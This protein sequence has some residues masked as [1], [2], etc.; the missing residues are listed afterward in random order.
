LFPCR[1]TSNH[2]MQMDLQE[3]SRNKWRSRMIQSHVSH[4][5]MWIENKSWLWKNIR[6]GCK[7]EHHQ[8]S[9][10]FIRIK[11][12]EG[13]SFGC[14]NGIFKWTSSWWSLHA[15]VARIWVPRSEHLVCKLFW[16][17]HGLKQMPFND[18]KKLIVFWRIVFAKV[19]I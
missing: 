15:I 2:Y 13:A 17:L 8:S 3:I 18:F 9:E 4:K 10:C 19:I 11:G 16:T 7:M 5:G 14:E 1:W 6:I 12:L